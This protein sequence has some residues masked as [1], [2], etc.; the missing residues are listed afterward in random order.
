[1]PIIYPQ[2]FFYY[3]AL[4][5]ICT[6]TLSNIQSMLLF[7]FTSISI[8]ITYTMQFLRMYIDVV[9]LKLIN[10]HIRLIRADI[11]RCT[12]LHLLYQ[13]FY[14]AQVRRCC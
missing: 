10:I 4:S 12:G 14:I 2:C 6:E 13:A 5:Y 1:M 11:V 7:N 8:K 3:C 9:Q